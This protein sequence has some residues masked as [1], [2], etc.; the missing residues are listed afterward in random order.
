MLFFAAIQLNQCQETRP[1]WSVTDPHSGES[2]I[3]KVRGLKIMEMN[4]RLLLYFCS[5]L[6]STNF[7]QLLKVLP[8]FIIA[9]KQLFMYLI[10]CNGFFTLNTNDQTR[11]QGGRFFSVDYSILFSLQLKFCHF[12][13]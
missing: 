3:Q 9:S 6:F 4:N 10:F 5:I 7:T 13:L 8:C 11:T 1:D 12:I 2:P